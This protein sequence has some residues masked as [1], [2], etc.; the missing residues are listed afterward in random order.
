MID[1][2]HLRGTKE[3]ISDQHGISRTFL[4][5]L[6]PTRFRSLLVDCPGDYGDPI[7]F[8]VSN[9]I[10]RAHALEVI[11]GS[12][13]LL[14]LSG[15]SAGA[16]IAGDLAADIAAKRVPGVDPNRLLGCALI[17]DPKRPEFAGAPGLATPPGYGI[18]G[19]RPVPD[20]RTWWGTASHDPISALPAD[21]MLRSLADLSVYASLD[22]MRW[23]MWAQSVVSVIA[24]RKLQ[25]WWAVWRKP[26]PRV[27]AAEQAA[28][29]YLTGRHTTDYLT[30]GI[31][32]GLAAAV[33]NA[34]PAQ[35]SA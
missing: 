21:N 27:I 7:P 6:D 1:V 12:G 33:N 2:I 35:E 15:Y 29:G 23:A 5:A 22:P 25:P 17:A 10:G 24:A 8:G 18:A 16:Y 31:C 11:A 14:V 3:P 9:D 26:L 28:L 20:V 30:E 13:N 4:N 32:V 19:Q 34:F